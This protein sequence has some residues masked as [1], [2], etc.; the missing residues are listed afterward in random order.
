MTNRLA[1]WER[2]SL[3]RDR[4]D[5]TSCLTLRHTHTSQKHTHFTNIHTL[6]DEVRASEI[7][8]KIVH[9]YQAEVAQGLLHIWYEWDS[10]RCRCCCV[11]PAGKANAR[12]V[13][14]L[15]WERRRH[16]FPLRWRSISSNHSHI[17]PQT[18]GCEET[19]WNLQL[20]MFP[21]CVFHTSRHV[22]LQIN[23]IWPNYH[24]KQ[25]RLLAREAEQTHN[26]C[27]FSFFCA[28]SWH[29]KHVLSAEFWRKKCFLGLHS[30]SIGE[31]I[32][33]KNGKE[34]RIG[35]KGRRMFL[36]VAQPWN[37]ALCCRLQ[38]ASRCCGRL[39]IRGV[40]I[41]THFLYPMIK[42]MLCV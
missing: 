36:S 5:K 17:N 32:P 33:F 21:M 6:A 39:L 38:W 22:H 14:E 16:S 35:R 27:T 15:L 11:I 18:G 29:Y 1:E 8:T 3:C 25:T 37:F 12:W 13:K 2:G 23:N 4:L 19:C 41:I 34:K 24:I 42:K 20:P 30:I 31:D 7:V 28:S 9:I 40:F 10:S 26:L